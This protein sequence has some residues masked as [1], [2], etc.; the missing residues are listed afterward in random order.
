MKF[1]NVALLF[2]LIL[3]TACQRDAMWFGPAGHT[4]P[5]NIEGTPEFKEGWKDGCHSGLATY[6]PAH[7][8]LW[9]SYYQNY[10]MLKNPD[11]TAAWHESFDFCRHFNFKYHTQGTSGNVITGNFNLV[12]VPRMLGLAGGYLEN[13]EEKTPFF[14]RSQGTEITE[15]HSDDFTQ[16]WEDGCTTGTTVYGEYINKAQNYLRDQSYKRDASKV[17]NRAYESAWYDGYHFCR[18]SHNTHIK[19]WESDWWGFFELK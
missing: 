12:F 18:Q 7:Y 14:I 5:Q 8:K 3:T 15:G 2:I 11:Y 16:G 17:G 1:R 19:N 13:F 4:L 6:G 9:Y 10:G